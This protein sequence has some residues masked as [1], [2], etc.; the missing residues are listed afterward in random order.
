MLKLR[1]RDPSSSVLPLSQ[2]TTNI[3]N[4]ARNGRCEKGIEE[5]EVRWKEID[6]KKLEE[7]GM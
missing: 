5:E 6:M 7:R 2:L 4:E 1:L 3:H